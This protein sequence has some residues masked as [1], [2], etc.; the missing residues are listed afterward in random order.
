MKKKIVELLAETLNKFDEMIHELKGMKYGISE[1]KAEVSQV[2]TEIVKLNLQTAEN[3][4]ALIKLAG[5]VEQIA[6]LHELVTKLEHTV[7]K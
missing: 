7:Y 2:K 6:N 5:E 3:T 1:V 4:R